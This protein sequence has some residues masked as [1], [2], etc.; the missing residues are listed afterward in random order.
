MNLHLLDYILN[1][2]DTWEYDLSEKPYCLKI[3]R[4]MGYIMFSYNMIE[5]DFSERIV[6]ESRGI[7]L[8]EEDFMPVCV[9]FFKFFNVQESYADEIDWK[10]ARVQEKLDGSII[11][12]WFD[13]TRD[14][15]MVSTN[16]T[17]D[18]RKAEIQASVILDGVEISSYF[19]LFLASDIGVTPDLSN[20]DE[21]YTYMFELTSPFNRIV[22]PYTETKIWHIGTRNNATLEEVNVDLGFDKPAEYPLSTLDEC[23]DAVSKL[24]YNEEGYVVVDKYWRRVKI[25]SPAY[26]TAHHSIN[27]GVIT[28]ERK[29]DMI[30]SHTH[31]DFLSM[32]PEY[33]ESFDVVLEA[34]KVFIERVTEDWKSCQVAL[35]VF[36]TRKEQAEYIK[37]TTCP[38]LMF[39]LL[40]E[41]VSSIDEWVTSM[42]R[43]KILKWIGL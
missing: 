33:T 13:D 23:L 21:G 40:D 4:D 6:R 39:S 34:Y 30:I 38:A 5:S 17:I 28:D 9:P 35:P 1:N 43:D 8:R 18:A 32:F 31:E 42:N 37:H 22:V 41:K 10:S 14:V 3:K 29:L 7:I 27:N 2:P 20:W 11:K 12:V 24:P 25:K 16:G 36:E 15:W 26:V 19:D